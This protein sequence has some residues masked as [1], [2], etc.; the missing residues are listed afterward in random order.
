MI[1]KNRESFAEELRFAVENE[2][3][4]QNA[5]RSVCIRTKIALHIAVTVYR[6]FHGTPETDKN[7]LCTDSSAD[8]PF[9]GGHFLSIL[10]DTYAT[11]ASIIDSLI[12]CC[13]Q[14]PASENTKT[15]N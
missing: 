6:V 5:V 1:Q 3:G 12:F 14:F 13:N 15:R 4:K 10:R 2:I 11:R 7:R 8:N 9:T